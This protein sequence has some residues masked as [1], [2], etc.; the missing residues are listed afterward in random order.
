ME[1]GLLLK[2]NVETLHRMNKQPRDRLGRFLSWDGTKNK[3]YTRQD[4]ESA[5]IAGLNAKGSAWEL[6]SQKVKSYMRSIE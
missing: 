5:F 2:L 6:P 1:T 4:I 3:K